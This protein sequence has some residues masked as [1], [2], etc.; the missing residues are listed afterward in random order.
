MAKKQ[1]NNVSN[2]IG[3]VIF[4]LSLR[5]RQILGRLGNI[6]LMLRNCLLWGFVLMLRIRVLLRIMRKLGIV[7]RGLSL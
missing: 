5:N 6:S 1:T 2:Q 7:M 3:Y 4:C